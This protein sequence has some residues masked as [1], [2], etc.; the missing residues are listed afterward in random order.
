MIEDFCTLDLLYRHAWDCLCVEVDQGPNPFRLMQAA[1]LGLDSF[2]KVRT[3]VLRKADRESGTLCFHT[4]LRS[5]KFAELQR[6]PRISMVGMDSIR[7]VQIRIEGDA[8]LI[9]TGQDRD[10]AWQAS[11]MHSRRLYQGRI[12]PGTPLESPSQAYAEMAPDQGFEHFCLVVV[13]IHRLEWL[14]VSTETHQRALFQRTGPIWQSLWVA[15]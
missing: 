10:A 8:R 4:D 2:P 5:D 13:S 1:T 9:T 7:N 15:P 3:V 14:D 11:R 6:D 12:P